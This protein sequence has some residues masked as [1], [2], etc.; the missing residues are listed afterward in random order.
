MNTEKSPVAGATRQTRQAWCVIL[1][2]SDGHPQFLRPPDGEPI[3]FFT[4]LAASVFARIFIG[5]DDRCKVIEWPM[6][7]V[8]PPQKPDE[9]H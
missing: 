8:Q 5:G 1:S 6:P 3:Y 4:D 9:W 2:D 7:L